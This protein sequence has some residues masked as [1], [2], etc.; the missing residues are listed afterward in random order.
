MWQLFIF[1][2]GA[3]S[4]LLTVHQD[5]EYMSNI[6]YILAYLNQYSTVKN[7][8]S[9]YGTTTSILYNMGAQ[10]CGNYSYL[11]ILSR[12]STTLG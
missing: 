5:T 3:I 6:E 12:F 7:I 9:I 8:Q 1:G 4:L 11:W 2:A 10:Y